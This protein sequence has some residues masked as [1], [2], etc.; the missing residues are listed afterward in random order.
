MSSELLRESVIAVDAEGV[1]L[2]K[3]GPMTLLQ[4]GTMTG[5]V[6]LFD[7]QENGNMFSKGRLATVLESETVIKVRSLQMVQESEKRLLNHTHI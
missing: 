2:G 1:Q 3:D 4:I 5:Q 7:I 6:Y